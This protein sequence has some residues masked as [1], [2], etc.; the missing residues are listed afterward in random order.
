MVIASIERLERAARPQ[1][2]RLYAGTRRLGGAGLGALDRRAVDRVH[3]LIAR[4]GTDVRG[5][6]R[7][8][9]TADGPPTRR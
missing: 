4:S 5:S 6:G 1:L 2:D 9:E 7:R 8:R 3:E